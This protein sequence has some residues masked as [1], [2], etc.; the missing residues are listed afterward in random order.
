M[1]K[2]NVTVTGTHY[3]KTFCNCKYKN[4]AIAMAAC[5]MLVREIEGY[6]GEL[7]ATA[8]VSR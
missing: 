5:I 4:K 2:F 3:H 6:T 8:R 1:S 7:T